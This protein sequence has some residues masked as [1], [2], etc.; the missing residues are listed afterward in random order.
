MCAREKTKEKKKIAKIWKPIQGSGMRRE[1]GEAKR[2][3][4]AWGGL[5][6]A[7]KG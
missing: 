7:L 6:R 3:L 1:S 5:G 2:S 4:G